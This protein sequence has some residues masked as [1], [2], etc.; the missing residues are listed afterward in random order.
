MVLQ[1][2]SLRP[3]LVAG[4]SPSRVGAQGQGH[5]GARDQRLVPVTDDGKTSGESPGHMGCQPAFVFQTLV[6]LLTVLTGFSA[7]QKFSLCSRNLLGILK[8]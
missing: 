8:K 7:N 2:E 5:H 4:S 6:I 3:E 1:G